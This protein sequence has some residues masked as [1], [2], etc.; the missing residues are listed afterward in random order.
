MLDISLRATGGKI[1]A[2]LQLSETQ[3]GGTVWAHQF[4]IDEKDDPEKVFLGECLPHL[5]PAL[6]KSIY[7]LL[8][9]DP[10]ATRS[11]PL[12]IQA[13]GTMS[14]LGWHGKSFAQAEVLL[15][16]SLALEPDLA[17]A[18]ATLALVL[19]LGQKVGFATPSPDIVKEAISLADTALA[20]DDIDSTVLGV[21]G[22]A[23]ADAG[24]ISRAK[25]LLKR[26]LLADPANA[27]AL[28]AVGWVR[29][30]QGD[31]K[32]AADFLERS[33]AVS[34]MDKRRVIWRSVLAIV[35][36][37][38]GELASELEQAQIAVDA[39]YRTYFSRVMMTAVQLELNDITAAR[40]ALAECRRVHLDLTNEEVSA[41]LGYK[42]GGR[43]MEMSSFVG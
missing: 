14:V 29:L 41:I 9:A 36:I 15:R 5:E 32:Q 12:L 22:C 17:L 43:I 2:N 26:A 16:K 6:V 1:A 34:P 35:Q 24:E 18:N 21:A 10:T 25:P 11:K 23:L 20:L 8:R 19:A 33:I 4:Q 31:L 28:A 40:T 3:R 38:I 37:K 7:E 39:D 27:Q 30:H 42:L 13:L